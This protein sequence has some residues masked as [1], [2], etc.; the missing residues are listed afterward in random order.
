MADDL[1]RSERI[2]WRIGRLRSS[3]RG[4][5]LA[6][7]LTGGRIGG[8]MRGVPVLLL[9]TTGRRSGA[10]KTVPLMYLA[11]GDRCVVVATNFASPD[12]DPAWWLNLQADPTAI[13]QRGSI[14][15]S[16]RAR[17]LEGEELD[18]IWPRLD[19][20]NRLWRHTTTVT[21]RRFRPSPSNLDFE[22][23]RTR[24]VAV[25][26]LLDIA[27]LQQI[28]PECSTHPAV[29]AAVGVP[30]LSIAEV[31][32]QTGVGV[33]TLRYYERIGLLQVPR[34]EAGRRVYGATE[35]GRVVFISLLRAAA[36]PIRD[37]QEYFGLVARGPGNE[38]DRVEVLERHREHV[39]RSLDEL[40]SALQLIELKLSLY[41]SS[42]AP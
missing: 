14:Q 20:L 21:D 7:R 25:V 1:T 16:V 19:Q 27:S 9:T 15:S 26:A 10:Q 31:A 36:M 28:E 4:H 11:D 42:I 18:A 38:A 39:A 33:H 29:A 23:A 37:L 6:Y 24:I 34:D 41:R 5:R 35:I 12:R 17:R 2:G 32:E 30:G 40:R 3:Y 8:R 22:R 13:I